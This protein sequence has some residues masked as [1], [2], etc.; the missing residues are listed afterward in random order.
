MSRVWDWFQKVLGKFQ[1]VNPR[2]PLKIMFSFL[3]GE[4]IHYDNVVFVSTTK[5]SSLLPYL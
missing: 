1:P 4:L 5:N 2:T 3:N